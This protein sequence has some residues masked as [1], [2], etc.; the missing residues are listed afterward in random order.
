MEDVPPLMSGALPS[1]LTVS[2]QFDPWAEWSEWASY[3]SASSMR[4]YETKIRMQLGGSRSGVVVVVNMYTPMY[5][6]GMVLEPLDVGLDT[7]ES[8]KVTFNGCR[9][10][11]MVTL[12]RI[13]ALRGITSM[14]LSATVPKYSQ[15]ETDY[16]ILLRPDQPHEMLRKWLD[17]TQ[18]GL[19]NRSMRIFGDGPPSLRIP[20]LFN[21]LQTRLV[22]GRLCSTVLKDVGFSSIEHVLPAI[23]TPY[24]RL[25]ANYQRYEFFGDSILKCIVTCQLF[26]EHPDWSEGNFSRN[27]DELVSNTR[28][29]RAALELGLDAFVVDHRVT[30]RNWSAPAWSRR[31]KSGDCCASTHGR[32]MSAKVLADVVEALI[33]AAYLDGG[34]PRA[35]ACAQVLLPEIHLEEIRFQPNSKVEIPGTALQCAQTCLGY[36][37]KNPSLLVEALT[38]PSCGGNS[39]QRLEFLGDAVLDMIIVNRLARH[40]TEMTAGEMSMIKHAASNHNILAFLCLNS[41]SCGPDH[42]KD[43]TAQGTRDSTQL[44]RLMRFCGPSPEQ[45][46]QTVLARYVA[47]RDQ[48]IFGLQDAKEY[49]W[50]VLIKLNADKYFSDIVESVLGA[51]FVDSIGDVVACEVFLGNIGLLGYLA[52]IL[53]DRVDI[54]HPKNTLQRLSRSL[55]KF[56]I[57]R[58]SSADGPDTLYECTVSISGVIIATAESCLCHEGA[59]V[60][61]AAAA[62]RHLQETPLDALVASKAY[63]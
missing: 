55:A 54:A 47:L 60:E 17:G 29:T 27:R 58:A 52:R 38:H 31:Q 18:A 46:Q 45:S 19:D 40:P 41:P 1:L 57:K 59:E 14:Y 36:T 5:L 33:G 12:D 63:L 25:Q 22:A 23:T 7:Q 16:L 51:I 42:P 50:Q 20:A 30:F 35:C 53:N 49:P 9:K 4:L 48:I 56:S 2:E 61:A 21:A 26:F 24:T 37:F 10:L 11:S 8:V 44:W 28:L 43:A 62:I 15:Q 3:G 34:L 39:Y 32:S 13:N 6:S